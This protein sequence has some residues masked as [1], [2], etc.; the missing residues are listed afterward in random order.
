M[1][2]FTQLLQE[3]PLHPA[4]VTQQQWALTVR[5][6][7]HTCELCN[8]DPPSHRECHKSLGDRDRPTSREVQRTLRQ[9][10]KTLPLGNLCALALASA[11]GTLAK[12]KVGMRSTKPQ[13]GKVRQAFQNELTP[14][15]P[16]LQM[17]ALD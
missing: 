9:K 16:H 15:T 11:S 1:D 6:N 14:Q 8:T 12:G 7:G 10:M 3:K 4:A 13:Q 5:R 2:S 17:R